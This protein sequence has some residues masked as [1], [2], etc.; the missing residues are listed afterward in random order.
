MKYTPPASPEEKLFTA[1]IADL[2]KKSQKTGMAEFSAFLN[3]RERELAL[4]TASKLSC[5]VS[6][7][8]GYDEAERVILGFSYEEIGKNDFPI[9]PLDFTVYGEIDH[10][11]ILGSVL[12]LGLTREPV[13][14]I[15]LSEKG[16]R[17]FVSERIA[18]FVKTELTRVG[19]MKAEYDENGEDSFAAPRFEEESDT[20][21]SL[22]LDSVIAAIANLSRND[23]SSLI[24]KGFV[25]VNHLTV[26]K[27][28]L[29]VDTGDVISVRGKG[30]FRIDDTGKTTKK[31]R[32]VLNYS[33]YL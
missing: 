32:I 9:V 27:A 25:S 19:R 21:A 2:I 14:D 3:L 30:K 29:T 31:G 7:F 4:Q 8:G 26:E 17:I 33:K 28:T 12:A 1:R 18:E 13:G 16:F 24:E 5:E 6:V 15:L 23:A 20:V 11:D 10:R 22:R